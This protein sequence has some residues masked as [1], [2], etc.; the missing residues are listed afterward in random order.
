MEIFIIKSILKTNHWTDKI[1]DFNGEKIVGS[2]YEKE[3]L[4]SKL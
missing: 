4:L 3:L 2:F 1:K